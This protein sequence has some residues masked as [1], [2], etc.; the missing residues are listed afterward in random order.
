MQTT[1]SEYI[2][3]LRG[4]T[5]QH[6]VIGMSLNS[7]NLDVVSRYRTGIFADVCA[8]KLL[9]EVMASEPQLIIG[10]DNE[11]LNVR[12]ESYVNGGQDEHFKRVITQ[13]EA[14]RISKWLLTNNI[15]LYNAECT[16]L[17][18]LLTSRRHR[19][20]PRHCVKR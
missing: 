18:S 7:R 5:D 20:H 12:I 1:I 10:Y 6:F 11:Q 4:Q 14:V 17:T 15:N 19:S 8:S 13:H 3:L 9:N 2:K 16:G